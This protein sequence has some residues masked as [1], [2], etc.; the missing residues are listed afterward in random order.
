MSYKFALLDPRPVPAAQAAND[1][2]FASGPVYGVEVT[3]PAL[4]ARCIG[5]L[6]PQ[7]TGGDASVAA[8]EA[9]LTAELP[10]DGATFVTIRPDPDAF[11][12]MLVLEARQTRSRFYWGDNQSSLNI[13]NDAYPGV[14]VRNANM[15]ERI[16][17]IAAADKFGKGGWPGVRPLPSRENPWLENAA[18][19]DIHDLAAIS[20]ALFDYKIPVEQRVALMR[21][22]FL[23]G[24]EPKDYREKVEAERAEMIRAL[25][26][27]EIKVST[28]AD[29][30]IAVVESS[31]RAATMIGYTQAPVV[32]ARNPAH[33][34]QGGEPHTKYTVCA[35]TAEEA[36]IK[37]ALVE[38]AQME[39]GWGGSPTIGGSPQGVSSELTTDE[40]VAVVARHL[41]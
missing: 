22:W 6:D 35:F 10:P 25:E 20:A 38:L 1:A 23:T 8:I 39:P 21:H 4:A 12:A 5:N 40:V 17:T 31:H 15:A 28:V 34:V 33:R 30:R 16:R 9:A 18:A 19:E 36:D 27:G 3:V 37:S 2:I 26:A 24:L 29:G 7:H 14:C 41:K 11:G 32:V 13:D